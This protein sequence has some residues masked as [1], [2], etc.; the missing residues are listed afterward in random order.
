MST[1]I[2]LDSIWRDRETYPNPNDYQLTPK[3]VD[4]WFPSARTVRAYPQNPTI[5][6]LEFATTVN[7]HYLTLPFS[8]TVSEFPRIYVNFRSDRYKDIHLIQAIDGKQPDAKFICNFDR[9]QNDSNGNPMWIHY[10]CSM[11]QTMRF[12]RGRPVL[13]Q[14]TTRD[15]SILPNLDTILP[16]PL[17][18]TKQTL[19]T[20]ELTPYIRDGDYDNHLAETH[21]T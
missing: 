13:F 1:F 9:I 4:T 20:F 18:P 6:P 5:Q 11:E 14:I 19:C 8:E 10:K 15:G 16:T 17:D 12:D 3:Q 7:I 21:T 2:D